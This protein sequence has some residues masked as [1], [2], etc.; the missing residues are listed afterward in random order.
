M[1]PPDDWTVE[2]ADAALPWVRDVLERLRLAASVDRAR[3]G[4]GHGPAGGGATG[5]GEA[6]EAL[7]ELT[8]AGIVLRDPARSLVDFPARAADGRTYLLCWLP[9]EASVTWWHWPEDGFAGRR[10][11]SDPPG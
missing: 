3:S 1:P 9:D 2:E 7:D 10:P 6:G 8:A 5:P 11:L 4:N